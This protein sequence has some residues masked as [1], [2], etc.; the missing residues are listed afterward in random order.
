MTSLP[1]PLRGCLL[2]GLIAGAAGLSGCALIERSSTLLARQS[3]LQDPE[4]LPWALSH[5]SELFPS[6]TVSRASGGAPLQR[7]PIDLSGV[8]FDA[9]NGERRRLDAHFSAN[10]LRGLVVLHGGRLVFE[11]YADDVGP[12]TRFTSWSVAKSFTSTLVGLAVAAGAI[13][14]LDDPIERYLP[15]AVG[16]GYEGVTIRQAL[17]MS[18]GVAFTEVYTDGS[19]DVMSFMTD[20]L[21]LN[22][23]RANQIAL[24][25]PRAHEPGTTFNYNTAETQV[26]GAVV[27]AATGRS[28]SELLQEQIWSR[29]GM[30]H[31]ASWLLD[32]EGPEGVEMAGCCLNMALRDQARF[33]QLFLQDGMWKGE[34]ILPPGWV[35]QATVPSEEHLRFPPEPLPGERG[36]QYQ[37]WW[38]G[39]DVYSAEG[40]NGQLIWIDP[41]RRVVIAQAAAWPEAWDDELAA[42]A[43][44]MLDAIAEYV[45]GRSQFAEAGT[46]P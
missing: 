7:D 35:E 1:R 37:W 6:R 40:V 15:D 9:G 4:E 17:Q 32:R 25:F 14:S 31:D 3:A 41:V 16:T 5:M 26:L 18:S 45:S 33:G 46:R 12:T 30:Q 20:S 36:Y 29:L 28:L 13:E 24:D 21:V 22:R 2:V 34:R 38:L 11:R 19:A 42:D 43:F 23:K 10:H 39:G 8:S 27:S 44:R